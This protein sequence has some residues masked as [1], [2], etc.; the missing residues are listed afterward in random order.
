MITL[1]PFNRPSMAGREMELLRDTL[2]AEHWSG[3]GPMTAQAEHMLARLHDEHAVLLTTNC[4]HALELAARL[5]NT[6]PGDEVIVPAFTFMS[7]ASAF[8]FTGARPV[9]VDVLPDT[10]NLDPDLV[11]GAITDRTAAIVTVH[12]AGIADRVDEL[13]NIAHEHMVPLIEDNAH[14]LGGTYQGRT[15]GTFGDISTLSFHETKNI[16]CGEGGAIVINDD[17][18]VARAELLREKG[19]DRA[20]FMRGQIDKYTWRDVGSSWIPSDLLAALLVAQLER[21]DQIQA[22]RMS[23]WTTYDH[24]LREWSTGLG[25]RQPHVPHMAEHSAHM[26]YLHMADLD[27]RTRFIAH[28]RKA[29]IVCTFHYQALNTSPQGRLFNGHT[30]QC[31]VA[32]SASE[33]LVRLP[34][35]NDMTNDD[36]ARVITAC[37]L[38]AG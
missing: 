4:T 9:F 31:P 1:L 27:Q 28:M 8:A 14:G 10:L 26:Y 21:F 25:V 17:R 16:S 30:G 22:S 5:A 18:L 24:A 20:Q 34:L 33:T 23:T 35:F 7:T 29:G 2:T 32:E 3:N 19:T 36:R 15:L 37:L 11:R 13:V 38:F 6:M 12:Y